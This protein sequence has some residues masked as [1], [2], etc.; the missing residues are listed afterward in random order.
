MLNAV[1]GDGIVD[2]QDAGAGASAR[3]KR[4]PYQRVIGFAKQI[5]RGLA[6]AHA[7]VSCTAISS[8]PIFGSK[9][10]LIESKFSTSD[11]P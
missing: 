5:C 3:E 6:A 10:N 7:R 11:W 2:G 8:L 4:L 1:Y 9:K